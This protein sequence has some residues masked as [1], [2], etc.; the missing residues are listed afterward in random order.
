MLAVALIMAESTETMS[1]ENT[2]RWLYPLWAA[3]FGH[4]SSQAWAEIHHLIR[5][6]GHFIGYGLVS[7]CFYWSWRMTLRQSLTAGMWAQRRRAALLAIACTLTLASADEFHQRFLPSRTSS[8]YDVGIDL[9]GGLT[10][11]TLLFA[12][13]A[14]FTRPAMGT[15]IPNRVSIS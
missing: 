5:K 1:A 2:S 3:V 10:A 4:V 15:T 8:I 12:A 11:Q 9:S 6:T 13:L 14:L 7:L